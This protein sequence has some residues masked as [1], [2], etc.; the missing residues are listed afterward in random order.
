MMLTFVN[1]LFGCLL[2]YFRT[3][4]VT[5]FSQ[6]NYIPHRET[7][8]YAF[9]SLWATGSFIHPVFNTSSLNA[10]L[11]QMLVWVL[12]KLHGAKRRPRG[13]YILGD[14]ANNWINKY[15]IYHFG[16]GD[17]KKNKAWWQSYFKLG[18]VLRSYKRNLTY[19]ITSLWSQIINLIKRR[20]S[21]GNWQ[22][23]GGQEHRLW[24]QKPWVWS[25]EVF[26]LPVL[27]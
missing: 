23:S 22:L 19:S 4:L 10:Y 11:C 20:R 3:I 13:V 7:N 15:T 5:I 14:E 16:L 17:M 9:F 18:P 8:I 2:Y 21:I 25:W 6:K 26:Q 1:S 27:A 24:S 12:V